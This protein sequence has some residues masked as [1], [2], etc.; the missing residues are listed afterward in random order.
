LYLEI[1]NKCNFACSFCIANSHKR[2]KDF[3]TLEDV[4]HNL[5]FADKNETIF[6]GG[7]EPT[8]HRNLFDI[9]DLIFAK[10]F[11]RAH[12]TTN[13]SDY[14]IT[15]KLIKYSESYI[16]TVV[17]SLDEYHDPIEERTKY[18]FTEPRKDLFIRK[19]GIRY[20]PKNLIVKGGRA[21]VGFDGCPH[22]T[23][24]VHVSPNGTWHMCDEYKH[25]GYKVGETIQDEHICNKPNYPYPKIW[26]PPFINHE[27]SFDIKR[28]QHYQE[29]IDLDVSDDYLLIGSAA[30][31]GWGL[32]PFNNDIDIKVSNM[33]IDKLS[34]KF[35][36]KIKK[37]KLEHNFWGNGKRE[38]I[39]C[40][41]I[42]ILD[43]SN[44]WGNGKLEQEIK[45]TITITENCGYV[46][47][48]DKLLSSIYGYEILKSQYSQI[49]ESN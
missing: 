28:I 26:Y 25:V 21:K 13:G 1:T 49:K 4:E 34:D 3:M 44:F 32:F 20:T 9:I 2:N 8:L 23:H 46:Q 10:G 6:I 38:Y 27:L 48:P 39:E 36:V 18:L 7:G 24:G 11:P 29:L 45:N 30:L 41:N 5:E 42:D 16:L 14:D 31:V 47:T 40:G 43:D 35:E 15:S 22:K 37:S 17:L 33:A 12:I 19:Y